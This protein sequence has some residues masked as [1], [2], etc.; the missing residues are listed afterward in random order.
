M[1][2]KMMY[3]ESLGFEDNEPI[4]SE[5]TAAVIN[6]LLR[7]KRRKKGQPVPEA[8]KPASAILPIY[9]REMGT[10]PLIDEHQ[11]VELAR[12]LQEAREGMAKTARKIPAATPSFRPA[13]SPTTLPP[14]S[15][16]S[17]RLSSE[18]MASV[19]FRTIRSQHLRS[20]FPTARR[21]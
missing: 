16:T 12:E 1:A 11:E 14:A 3:D 21:W 13:N 2:R 18:S 15:I 5:P 4:S 8:L 19:S 9:L 6:S 20:S 17:T 7:P 10:T